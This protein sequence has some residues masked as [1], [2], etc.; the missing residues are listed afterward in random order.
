MEQRNAAL[1]G[2]ALGGKEVGRL[3]ELRLI[4][5]TADSAGA[6]GG[7]EL[8]RDGARQSGQLE[9]L[10]F[11]TWTS[12]STGPVMLYFIC[13]MMAKL[14]LLSRNTHIGASKITCKPYVCDPFQQGCLGCVHRGNLTGIASNTKVVV[15]LC[16]IATCNVFKEA[17]KMRQ[18][19]TDMPF[20][21][22]SPVQKRLLDLLRTNALITI[23]HLKHKVIS[24]Y[25]D[26]FF[27]SFPNSHRPMLSV[28]S[29]AP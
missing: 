21:S 13:I 27:S 15:M 23:M 25:K 22:S 26:L 12:N 11:A 3:W 5:R 29:L 18:Y 10:L 4:L 6:S 7:G 16:N 8:G 19:S 9:R 14:E 28:C 17:G 2:A 24:F 20:H 1:V